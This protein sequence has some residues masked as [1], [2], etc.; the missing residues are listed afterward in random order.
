MISCFLQFFWIA[1][2]IIEVIEEEKELADKA[3][4]VAKENIK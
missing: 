1:D 4:N 3:L 2:R